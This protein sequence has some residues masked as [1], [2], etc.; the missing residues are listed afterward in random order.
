MR[1]NGTDVPVTSAARPRGGNGRHEL[2]MDSVDERKL[3]EV[4][5]DSP[6]S[7]EV[8]RA[9]LESYRQALRSLVGDDPGERVAIDP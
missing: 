3:L 2:P 5:T 8:E 1:R 7:V 6:G 4:L 9:Y